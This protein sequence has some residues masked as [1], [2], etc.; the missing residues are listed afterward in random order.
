MIAPLASF[1][2]HVPTS[3]TCPQYQ[4]PSTALHVGLT[5]IL[6]RLEQRN[7]RS[8]NTYLRSLDKMNECVAEF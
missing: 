5:S 8:S 4:P 3:Y 1:W 2:E 7:A 6:P